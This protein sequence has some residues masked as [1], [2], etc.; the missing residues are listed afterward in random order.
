[1]V[2]HL[3]KNPSSNLFSC[4]YLRSMKIIST[5][6]SQTELLAD[7]GLDKEVLGIT[8]FCVHP[9]DWFK[10]K[11]RVGGT[12]NLDLKKIDALNPSLILANKEENTKEEILE[13]KKKYK[14]VVTNIKTVDDNYNLIRQI[15]KLTN[16]EIEAAM[17][18]N[19]FKSAVSSIKSSQKASVAYVIWQNPYMVAG[20][21]TFINNMLE[22]CGFENVFNQENRYPE[23]TIE[24][25]RH[26]NP[27][28]V[29]LSSEPYPFKEKHLKEIESLLPN[30]KIMLVDGE[31][32]SWYGTRIIKKATYLAKMA[33]KR[34]EI[35]S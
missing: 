14:V 30:S 33:G 21:D 5:V 12:K 17:L 18:S 19:R 16:R 10:N 32:F 3:Y 26:L 20:G 22:L 6:P 28:Y 2:N 24:N 35:M 34:F 15:G 31:A 11:I 29:F 8:K 1:M 13:L 7:L 23:T 25:L 4:P 9:E 27:E